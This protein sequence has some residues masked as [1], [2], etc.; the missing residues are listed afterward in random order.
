[1]DK[2][3]VILVLNNCMTKV[4]M[5]KRAK[6]PYKGMFNLVG[7]RIEEF[8]DGLASANRELYEETGIETRVHRL[9]DFD[10][11]MADIRLECYVCKVDEKI[12][13]IEE[14]NELHWVDINEDF[15]DMN[16]FAGEGNIG[17]MLEHAKYY[18]DK[19]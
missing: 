10:Y 17:H 16:R 2:Y 1:M 6:E 14:I 3:N 12:E 19:F 11:H 5:C 9:M 15:Y 4:L 18:R 7:G 8:E 13:L